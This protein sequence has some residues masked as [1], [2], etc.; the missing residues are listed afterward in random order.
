[1]GVPSSLLDVLTIGDYR[2]MLNR[3]SRLTIEY[4]DFANCNQSTVWIQI[5]PCPAN[6][7]VTAD[8]VGRSPMQNVH[9]RQAL[10]QAIDKAD[11]IAEAFA[12]V[13]VAAFSPTMPGVSG[14]PTYTA[15]TTPLPFNPQVALA[16]L[17]TALG[18]LGVAEPDPADVPPASD[19]CDSKCQHTKAWVKML[20]PMRF[21]YNCDAGHDVRVMYMAEHWRDALGFSGNQLDVRCTDFGLFPT[22]RPDRTAFYDIARDGWGADFPHP[23]NQLR[24]TFACDSRYNNST[25][26]NPAFEALLDQGAHAADYAVSLPLYHQAEQLLVQDAPALFLRYGEAI[27]LIRPWVI[28]YVQTPSDHQNVGDTFYENIQI[29]A[30]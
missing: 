4:W 3:S 29:L 13:G 16:N 14:F 26:C 18:E 15:E 10:T 27:S 11:M 8:V 7:A 28:N 22:H 9:F 20:D 21:N 1:V 24:E 2:T 30:H 5:Q 12:G 19:N 23:D 6:D 17:A 25:Y